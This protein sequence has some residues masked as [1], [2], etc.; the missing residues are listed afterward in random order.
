MLDA[1][2][3]RKGNACSRVLRTL[4]LATSLG[5]GLFGWQAGNAEG[6]NPESEGIIFERQQIMTQ[7]GKDA[8]TLGKIVA[9]QVPADKLAETTK[10]IAQG[11]HD[12]VETFKEQVPGG[13]TKPEVWSNYAD[14]SARLDRFAA[15]ADAMAKAGTTGNV[16]AVTG[17]LVEGMPCKECHDL[18]RQPKH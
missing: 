18:Y 2:I 9:G 11:A 12:S 14:F 4:T 3:R 10:A 8:E 5:I 6:P 17:L 1:R 15:G 13:R 7:L 16:T